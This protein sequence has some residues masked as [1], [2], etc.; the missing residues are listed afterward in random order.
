MEWQKVSNGYVL[1]GGRYGARLLIGEQPC[2]SFTLDGVNFGEFPA[3]T[4]FD[5]LEEKEVLYDIRLEKLELRGGIPEAVFSAKSSVWEEHTFI[6]RFEKRRAEFFHRVKG[7]GRLGRC[8]FFSTGIPGVY[9]PGDSQ[10]YKYNARIN[11]EFYFNPDTNLGNVE[12]CRNTQYGT[13]GLS[14][15]F[16][17]GGVFLP[18]RSQG[19]FDPSP[20]CFCFYDGQSAMGIGLGTEPGK[21]RFSSFEYSGARKHGAAFYINYLGYTRADGEYTSPHVSFTF[22]SSALEVLEKHIDWLDDRGFSTQFAYEPASW[23]RAPVFCG[24]AEQTV[25]APLDGIPEGAEAT[26][27]NYEE[28]IDTLERRGIP[29]STIV[30][31]DKWQKHYGTFEVDEEKW[32]DMKGFI[33]RQHEKGRHVLLWTASYHTEGLPDELCI[34]NRDGR[35]L[36]ADVANPEYERLIRGQI[37]RLVS[38]FGADGFKEDWIGGCGRERDIPGYGELHGIEMVRRFQYILWDAAHRAKADALVETQTPH[39]LFRE[40]SDALRLNDLW[41]S[42]RHVCETMQT[43]ARI[44]RIAGWQVLDCDN[45]SCT[46]AKAWFRYMQLQPKLATPALYCVSRTESFREEIPQEMWDYLAGIW[47]KY[48]RENVENV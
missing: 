13:T 43:R 16:P 34:F 11:A 40:S 42:T 4:A 23:H 5:R 3:A 47:K 44:S 17:S 7:S 2:F 33:A 41:F 26:Q 29:L 22:G 10:G 21:Y 30:I 45:A 14:P 35:K 25:K 39:P 27:K 46:T 9:D 18:E 38:E 36:F 6:W 28:W 20:L 32:P 48:I 8:L 19:G 24:W 1:R 15:E 31:D 12:E 37:T